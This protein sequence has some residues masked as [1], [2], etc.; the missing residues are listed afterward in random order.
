MSTQSVIK[1]NNRSSVFDEIKRRQAVDEL[2]EMLD[3]H[4]DP[5]FADKSDDEIMEIVDGEIRKSRE[6]RRLKS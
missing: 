3:G 4:V 5:E 6:E 1:E 2:R